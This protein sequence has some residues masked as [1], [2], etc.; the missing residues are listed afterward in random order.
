MVI[1]AT[2]VMIAHEFLA[3]SSHA[4]RVAPVAGGST[5]LRQIRAPF[6]FDLGRRPGERPG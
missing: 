6:Q 4:R 3:S 1:K 5:L 2:E